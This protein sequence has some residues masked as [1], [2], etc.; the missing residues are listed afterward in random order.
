MEKVEPT[1]K[2]IFT[3]INPFDAP[4]RETIQPRLLL[5]WFYWFL[6]DPWLTPVVKTL[7]ELG[8][9]GFY[10]SALH[11]PKPEK[12]DQPYHWYVSLD[13][14][15]SY[16]HLVVSQE[17]AIYSVNSRWGI[18]CSDADHALVGGPD[19]LINNIH[20]SVP[21]LDYR[22]NEF[23]NAWK[24][25]HRR[26]KVDISWIPSML[27]HVYGSEK[28]YDLLRQAQIEWLLYDGD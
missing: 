21:D 6:D 1:F 17:N 2:A 23:L 5:Y 9:E 26:N 4:F 3:N 13:E 22:V 19:L 20:N 18:I 15:R 12:Q 11:R 8:E 10:V 16:G 27:S 28:A 14:V 24:G 7:Q 25:Y